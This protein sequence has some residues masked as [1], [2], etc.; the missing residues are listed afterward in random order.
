MSAE[1]VHAV[2]D[3][4]ADSP[5][6]ADEHVLRAAIKLFAELGYDATTRQMIIQT[7]GPGATRSELLR[8]GKAAVY[9]AALEHLCDLEHRYYAEAARDLVRDMAGLHRMVDRA[10]DFALLHPEVPAVWRHRGLKDA[11]DLDLTKDMRPGLETVLLQAPWSGVRPD[12][13]LQFVAWSVV[14]MITG[15]LASGM[16]DGSAPSRKADD[17][18]TLQRF[19]TELHTMVDLRVRAVDC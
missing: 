5:D 12:A 15:F 17:P 9:R 14:W 1:P 4:A 7:A 8:E 6:A 16:P 11:S 10:L 13:D 19:H 18:R 2:H 3:L